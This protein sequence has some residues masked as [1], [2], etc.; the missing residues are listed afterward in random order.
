MWLNLD[1]CGLVCAVVTHG[2]LVYATWVVTFVILLPW[3]EMSIQ[4]MF[5]HIC[6]TSLT[7][8]A[9]WSHLRAM[10]SDPGVVPAGALP[11]DPEEGNHRACARCN[12]NFKPPRAHHC[13]TCGRCVS[14]MDHHCPWVNNCVGAL[15][16]K[17]FILFTSYVMLS[18]LY[19]FVLV[20]WM[21]VS[22]PATKEVTPGGRACLIVLVIECM[23]FGLFT[24]CMTCDQ[25]TTITQER[26]K[27][28]RLRGDKVDASDTGVVTKLA[29]VFGGT[30]LSLA[31][32]LPITPAISSSTLGYVLGEESQPLHS[33]GLAP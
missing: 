24:L 4:G 25:F 20:L 31:W 7:F 14:R 17:Y 23:L 10:T 33:V 19:A 32:L 15:N 21:F 18:S 16:Q 13:S 26:S 2:L 29:E 3:F 9:S 6:F 11:L 12:G 8:L 5:H 27:I 22:F 30:T 1:P 28:Q